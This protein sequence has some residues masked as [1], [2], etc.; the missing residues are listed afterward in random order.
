MHLNTIY[1][2]GKPE[3]KPC[4]KPLQSEEEYRTEGSL[5]A[6][7][8]SPMMIGTDIRLM[9]PIMQQVLLNEE[10]IA[11]Q[12][13]ST[14]CTATATQSFSRPSCSNTLQV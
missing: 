3:T 1:K 7:V 6:I 4:H 8:S 9:T 13:A 2:E 5:Y 12:Q 10:L 14:A 11:I